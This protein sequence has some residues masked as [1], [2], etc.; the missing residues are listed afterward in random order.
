M[1]RLSIRSLSTSRI[2]RRRQKSAPLA[3]SAFIS[4]ARSSTRL[5]T[6]ARAAATAFI[7]CGES[8]CSTGRAVEPGSSRRRGEQYHDLADLLEGPENIARIAADLAACQLSHG[9]NDYTGEAKRYRSPPRSQRHQGDRGADQGGRDRT[10][11]P[12]CSGRRAETVGAC[13]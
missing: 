13:R 1:G 9:E 7:W 11:R 2:S 4:S 8:I 12:R 6:A 3:G 10:E 5:A